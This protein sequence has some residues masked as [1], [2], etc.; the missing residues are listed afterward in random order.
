MK[1]EFLSTS[2]N[3][4]DEIFVLLRHSKKIVNIYKYNKKDIDKI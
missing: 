4:V 2:K 1:A 3:T